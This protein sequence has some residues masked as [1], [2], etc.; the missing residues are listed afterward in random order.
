VE[1][2]NIEFVFTKLNI[3]IFETMKMWYVPSRGDEI[4]LVSK[5]GVFKGEVYKVAAELVTVGTPRY[6]IRVFLG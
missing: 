3:T 1:E 5:D 2:L 4:T 6:K